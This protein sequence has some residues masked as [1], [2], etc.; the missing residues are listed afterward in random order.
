[1]INKI[2]P[3]GLLF[4]VRTTVQFLLFCAVAAFAIFCSMSTTRDNGMAGASVILLVPYIIWYRR[5]L[6]LTRLRSLSN[7]NPLKNG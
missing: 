6:E 3:G 1:M 4:F 7:K 5:A 2:L